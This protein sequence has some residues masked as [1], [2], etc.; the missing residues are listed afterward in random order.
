MNIKARL[1]ALGTTAALMAGVMVA[2]A[3]PASAVV[4]HDNFSFG[5][6][7]APGLKTWSISVQNVTKGKSAGNGMWEG[8]GDRLTAYD[9]LADGYAIVAYLS[10]GRTA[11]TVGQS[12]PVTVTKTGDLREN[13]TYKLQVCVVKDAFKRCSNEVN[14]KS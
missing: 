7:S 3:S 2:G 11:S 4:V 5:G 9:G 13:Q 8:N 10:T 1:G 14:V 6:L 12:S